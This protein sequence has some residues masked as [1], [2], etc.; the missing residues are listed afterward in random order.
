MKYT[1]TVNS[2]DP[3]VPGLNLS[4]QVEADNVLDALEA[5]RP[6]LKATVAAVVGQ[7]QGAQPAQ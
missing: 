3:A 2:A 5:A 1:V 7:L 6:A 4:V